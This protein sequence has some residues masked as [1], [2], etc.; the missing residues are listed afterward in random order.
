MTY[1]HN[2]TNF[3]NSCT[4]PSTILC[5]DIF[6][7]GLGETNTSA[8][9]P[10]AILTSG[11][12]NEALGKQYIYSPLPTED[13]GD[14]IQTAIALCYATGQ[15]ILVPWDVW[16]E[17]DTRYFGTVEEYGKL[18]HF[19]RQY[20]WLFDD[21]KEKAKVG[22]IVNLDEVEL[23][24]LQQKCMDLAKEGISFRLLVSRRGEPSFSITQ[25]DLKDLQVLIPLSDVEGLKEEEQQ[26]IAA[27]GLPMVEKIDRESYCQV[28]VEEDD[29]LLAVRYGV[30][31]VVHLINESHTPWNRFRLR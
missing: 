18:F 6:D 25:E 1:S 2:V 13:N 22:V 24:V 16:L 9:S 19:V 3:G 30:G 12:I 29:V 20:S 26:M 10:Q 23:T 21:H 7:A 28:E 15:Q 31:Q 8:L 17:G 14:V 5:Y 27:S 4:N 11:K